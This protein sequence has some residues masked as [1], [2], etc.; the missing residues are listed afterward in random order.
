MKMAT[1]TT[2]RTKT[3][4]SHLKGDKEFIWGINTNDHVLDTQI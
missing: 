2:N 4:S 1:T 3:T